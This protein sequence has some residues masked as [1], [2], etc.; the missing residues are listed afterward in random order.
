M[1]AEEY[2]DS[3]NATIGT[4]SCVG[5]GALLN[6]RMVP[7]RLANNHGSSDIM[8]YFVL[9]SMFTCCASVVSSNF[10]H[11]C[12]VSDYFKTEH[13]DRGALTAKEQVL[14]RRMADVTT[15]SEEGEVMMNLAS[16]EYP[17]VHL[18]RNHQGVERRR[19]RRMSGA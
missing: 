16:Q 4:D 9:S 15:N 7:A 13:A 10:H 1:R 19:R 14:T 18:K 17:Y 6:R 2:P 3:I 12:A 11:N 5:G 8:R